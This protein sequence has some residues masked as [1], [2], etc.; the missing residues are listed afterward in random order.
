MPGLD[1][2]VCRLLGVRAMGLAP[3]ICRSCTPPLPRL[4]L[5]GGVKSPL[6][7][8]C[9]DFVTDSGVER[10]CVLFLRVVVVE[11]IFLFTTASLA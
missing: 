5:D 1:G 7:V 10:T 8:V 9:A 6:F 4:M 11:L 2:G 3:G